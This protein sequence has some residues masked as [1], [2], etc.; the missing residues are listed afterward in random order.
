MEKKPEIWYSEYELRQFIDVATRYNIDGIYS[1]VSK[2][3]PFSIVFN[4]T[5]KHSRSNYDLFCNQLRKTLENTQNWKVIELD[6]KDRFL[7]MINRYIEWYNDNKKETEK[8]N[9]YNPY[10][11][12]FSIIE[13]TKKEIVKYFPDIESRNQKIKSV[14]RTSY[15]WQNNPDKELPELFSLM[16][17]ECKLIASETTYEQFKAIFTG[18]PIDEIKPIRWHQDNASELLYFIITLGQTNN[19]DYNPKKADYQKMKSCFVKPNGKSFEAAWKS[20]KTNID[21]NLSSDKRKAI[22]DLVNNF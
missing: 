10:E 15:E 17:Y 5:V 8:F 18:K 13:S 11:T 21:I 9:P 20:L 1:Q 16:L 6:L 7:L 2:D 14:K 12:M 3:Y 22:D 4:H 19:I